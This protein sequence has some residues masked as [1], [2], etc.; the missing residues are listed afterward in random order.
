MAQK[1]TLILWRYPEHEIVPFDSIAKD[2]FGTMNVFRQFNTKWQPNYLVSNK[3]NKEKFDWNYQN[4][5]EML[6]KGVNKER[7]KV[8][9]NLGYT[10]SFFSSINEDESFGYLLKVGS[11]KFINTLIIDIA[12]D[13]DLGD[14]ITA[15]RMVVLFEK[16][17]EK[18]KPFWGCIAN[19]SIGSQYGYFDLQ[20]KIPK[21][22]YWINYF[23]ESIIDNLN[24]SRMMQLADKN[25][26]VIFNK[27]FFQIKST[28]IESE[29]ESDMSLHTRID[30]YL[31]LN[32]VKL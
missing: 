26:E 13:V 10:I 1:H 6:K 28:A 29:S 12:L 8:F 19:E 32:K 2:A 14:K 17:V 25:E 7:K 24:E 20:K 11:T 5:S 27:G 18:F 9:L 22:I 23:D 15:N 4:F 16:L 30:E 31:G 21:T 3:K